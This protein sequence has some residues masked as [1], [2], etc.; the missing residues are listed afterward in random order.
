M[1]LH[2]GY[3]LFQKPVYVGQEGFSCA[4]LPDGQYQLIRLRGASCAN[5]TD[6]SNVHV[7]GSGTAEVAIKLVPTGECETMTFNAADTSITAT[8]S[9][10]RFNLTEPADSVSF[11]NSAR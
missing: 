9:V 10:F 1:R 2:L 4:K 7:K 6:T 5:D 8:F 3:P 11:L